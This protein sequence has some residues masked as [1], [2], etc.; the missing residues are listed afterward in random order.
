MKKS[1]NSSIWI[2]FLVVV[3]L[4]TTFGSIQLYQQIGKQENQSKINLYSLVPS[5]S[6]ALLEIRNISQL[7][8]DIRL[9]SPKLFN[10][11]QKYATDDFLNLLFDSTDKEQAKESLS[12]INSFILNPIL[13]DSLHNK[14]TLTNKLIV[15]YHAHKKSTHYMFYFKKNEV[16]ESFFTQF[17]HQNFKTN[18]RPK[19]NNY[20]DKKI[21]IYPLSQSS[22]YLSVYIGPTFIV[23]S[24]HLYLIREMI[25]TLND[26]TSLLSNPSFEEIYNSKSTANIIAYV[27][28]QKLQ[29]KEQFIRLKTDSCLAKWATFN[30]ELKRDKIY[31]T[32]LIKSKESQSPDI[33][34]V[35][36]NQSPI[37]NL[38]IGILPFSTVYFCHRSISNLSEWESLSSCEWTNEDRDFST[39]LS[40]YS[41][42]QVC[43][44]Q[45]QED[46][47][48]QVIV[49]PMN[50]EFNRQKLIHFIPNYSFSKSGLGEISANHVLD[51]FSGNNHLDL[52]P[53]WYVMASNSNLICSTSLTLLDQYVAQIEEGAL[54]DLN[55]GYRHI[56]NQFEVP[57]KLLEVDCLS[58]TI[59]DG[60][61]IVS[62]I[63]RSI[64][65]SKI[66]K[67]N[68]NA[69]LQIN[70]Q[71][72]HSFINIVLAS[73]RDWIPIATK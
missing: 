55:M 73:N 10:F 26:K 7:S 47:V 19:I 22:S 56:V 29:E 39:F 57:Y 40:Q 18:F 8:K 14:C 61:N 38:P 37:E 71:D 1:L 9:N 28:M 66:I 51:F 13:T 5:S 48:H 43:T 49:I 33:F 41:N 62:L 52:H 21:L 12:C 64:V 45:L 6:S 4:L 25:D 42:Q 24:N 68:Y 17:I 3:L 27:D 34:T 44:I 60:E 32:G 36:H 30:L 2:G 69:A 53:S 67:D 20:R 63:P 31:F 50:Q 70:N 23:F 35:L 58:Q 65:C 46:S 11:E 54:L 16:S 72:D 15:S 59:K